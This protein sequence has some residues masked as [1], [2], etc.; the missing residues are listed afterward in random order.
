[1][2][3]FNHKVYKGLEIKVLTL[4]PIY[5]IGLQNR[6]RVFTLPELSISKLQILIFIS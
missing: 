2:D 3:F 5:K 4:R 1:M 6:G